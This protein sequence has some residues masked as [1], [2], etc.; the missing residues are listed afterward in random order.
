MSNLTLAAMRL[1]RST[2]HPDFW[3]GEDAHG[4][5][6][7]WPAKPKGW[8]QRTGYAGAR[9]QL[10]EVEPALARG[11]GW[12]GAGRARKPRA[13]S[14]EASTKQLTIRLT[15][16]EHSKWGRAAEVRA[17][18]LAGWARDTLNSEADRTLEEAGAKRKGKP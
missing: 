5:L 1:Y 18:N 4:I 8:T 3:I 11:T 17:K 13:A 10:E 14:G 7:V 15:E 16:D 9:R 6:M 2:E 12:P